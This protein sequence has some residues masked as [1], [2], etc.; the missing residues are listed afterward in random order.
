[1]S[2]FK[3]LFASIDAAIAATRHK[4]TKNFGGSSAGVHGSCSLRCHPAHQR[5]KRLGWIKPDLD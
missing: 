3:E 2:F 5:L 4:S 1:M